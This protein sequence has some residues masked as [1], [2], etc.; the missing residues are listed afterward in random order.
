MLA[1]SSTMKEEKQKKKNL[2]E[3]SET[4]DKED[5]E[6][7]NKVSEGNS[8]DEEY[9]FNKKEEENKTDACQESFTPGAQSYDHSDDSSLSDQSSLY[10]QFYC[11]V[12]TLLNISSF[13]LNYYFQ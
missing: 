10:S 6:D 11:L 9:N 13:K 1:D 4:S 12:K 8:G 5:E 7:S 3:S 2:S